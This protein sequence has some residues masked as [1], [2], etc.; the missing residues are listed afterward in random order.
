MIV[1]QERAE[2]NKLL[3]I[4]SSVVGTRTEIRE[5][6]PQLDLS[7]RPAIRSSARSTTRRAG[8]SATTPSCG[9][10]RAPPTDA[11]SRSTRTPRS[12]GSSAT[13]IGSPRSR[14]H[15]AASSAD[16]SCSATAG[17][18]SLVGRARRPAAP[19]HDAHPP[20][21]R[22]RAREA[23]PRRGHRLLPAPRVRLADRSR[24]VPDRRRDR[25]VHD[26]QGDGHALVPRVLGRAR[27]RAPS[28]ARADEGAPHLDG[29]VRPLP[30]LQPDPRKD[31]DRQLP[32]LD[33]LGNVRLQGRAD[34]RR[35]ARRAGRERRDARR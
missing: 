22:H 26:V 4:D 6:C 21:L 3:G 30:R 18:S 32:R 14:R 15:A 5:L 8:S 9:A 20:G 31:G 27:A 29:P 19:D 34:R 12:P 11:A 1:M 35:H 10:S 7:E 2:V 28:A 16:R 25:A 13:A 23:V 33:R 17:W 24:R